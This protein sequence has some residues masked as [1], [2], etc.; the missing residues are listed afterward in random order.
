[1]K[2]ALPLIEQLIMDRLL[3]SKPP[4][5]A[6]MKMTG[7]FFSICLFFFFAGL[8]ALSYGLFL[9]LATQVPAF[10][11]AFITGGVLIGLTVITAL[12]FYA[13]QSVKKRQ[14]ER[15]SQEI[16]ELMSSAIETLRKDLAD[17]TRD[18]PETTL[19]ITALSGFI[20]GKTL[21]Q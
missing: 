14:K 12:S 5:S 4:V 8:T 13:Y 6:N 16:D 15:K 7:I 20:A 3:S 10:E 2:A 21:S 17:T 18:H 19:L 1:M 9:H 11:A